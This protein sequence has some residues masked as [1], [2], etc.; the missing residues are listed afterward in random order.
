[1]DE[2]IC[3]SV[4]PSQIMGMV[5]GGRP[6]LGA[7]GGMCSPR[8]RTGLL[9]APLFGSIVRVGSGIWATGPTV[10]LAAANARGRAKGSADAAMMVPRESGF[11]T[12]TTQLERQYVGDTVLYGKLLRALARGEA[13]TTRTNTPR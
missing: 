5:G 8:K 10:K 6:Q 2:Q 7:P 1:M 9:H 12:Q 11:T 13:I 3:P 4:K